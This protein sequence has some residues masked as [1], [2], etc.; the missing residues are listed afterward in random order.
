ML[1]TR[2]REAASAL[3]GALAARGIDALIEPMTEIIHH[4]AAIDLAGVCAV[5]CTSANGVHALAR[6]TPERQVMLFAVGDA[7]A[8]AGRA[9]GFTTV[10]SAGGNI[11][12]LVRLVAARL[13][14]QEG[15]LLYVRGATVAG[16]LAGRLREIG[17]SL[18]ERIVYEARPVAALSAC[19]IRALSAGRIDYALFFSPRTA[20]HFD[21]LA[22]TA[23]L[24]PACQAVVALSLSPAVD[25]ALASMPWR[26]RRV[27]ERPDLDALLAMLD[28]TPAAARPDQPP[29]NE[30]V[31]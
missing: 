2:P 11:D 31:G 20:A 19:V 1:L 26:E 30:H 6:A 16:N 9:R 14:P 22:A 4:D 15:R 7:S 8:A 24:A 17:F 29:E 23:G 28:R 13:R 12:D 25:A 27:A 21:R 3:A 10:E 18:E 5:L